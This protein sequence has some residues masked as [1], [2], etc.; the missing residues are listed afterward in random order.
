MNLY[1][2]LLLAQT[3]IA[4]ALAIVCVFTVVVISYLGSHSQ[5]ILKDN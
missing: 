3:P 1:R 4:V 2:K 5:E